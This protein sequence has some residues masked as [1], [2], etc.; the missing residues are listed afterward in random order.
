MLSTHASAGMNIMLKFASRYIPVFL[1]GINVGSGGFYLLLWGIRRFF[2]R[3]YD[4]IRK[5]TSLD[6]PCEGCIFQL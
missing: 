2:P 6:S 1:G 3:T 5:Q 4:F